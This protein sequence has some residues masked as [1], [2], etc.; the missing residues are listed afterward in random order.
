[1]YF[2]FVFYSSLSPVPFTL[3]HATPTAFGRTLIAG[4]GGLES[5]YLIQTLPCINDYSHPDL[6][7]IMIYMEVL[8]TLEVSHMIIM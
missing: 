1:M 8:G 7:S 4:V 3:E 2:C 6:P 5:N